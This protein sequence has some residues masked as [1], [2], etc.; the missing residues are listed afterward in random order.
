MRKGN[1]LIDD[2]KWQDRDS[3]CRHMNALA[4]VNYSVY[5][6]H[7]RGL[8]PHL[9][10]RD[11]YIYADP[12]T[13]VLVCLDCCGCGP[14]QTYEES[15]VTGPFIYD[16]NKEPRISMVWKLLQAV[17]QIKECLKPKNKEIKVL[18]ILLT[19]AT[20]MNDIDLEEYWESRDIMVL[21]GFKR[22]KFRN[23][24]VNDDTDLPG[25]AY[26]NA[27]LDDAVDEFSDKHAE[28][29]PSLCD[30][31]FDKMLTEFLFSEYENGSVDGDSDDES[32]ADEEDA[33][34]DETDESETADEEDTDDEEDFDDDD[35]D[36]DLLTDDDDDDDD[37]D[38]LGGLYIPDG[39]ITLTNNVQTSVEILRPIAN[40]REELDKLVGC[41]NIK[42]R[43]DELVALT[44]YNKRMLELFP[45]SKQ[46]SVSLHSIFLGR[47]GTGKTTV[48]K[49]FGS[50]MRQ[51]GALSK[52]HVVVCDRGT[53]IGGHWGDEECSLRQVLEKA[54]G[55]VLMIDEAY[56]L[57][58]PHPNDPGKIVIQLLMNIL[59][60]ESRRDIAVVLCGYKEPMMK[61]LD[62]NQGLAS[63]FPNRFEFKDF[64]VDEL[65]EITRRRLKDYEFI[66]TDQAWQKYRSVISQAYQARNSETWGNARFV[67]NQLE[68]I[69]IQH[70]SRCV[71][72]QPADKLS[73]RTITPDDIVPIE[74]PKPRARIGF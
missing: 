57:N 43:M 12:A 50:L 27:I 54:R 46:H 5:S 28:L 41:D 30:T 62:L 45:D 35:F 32:E 69:Y 20:I 71:S 40:P 15:K 1:R 23:I 22:L 3:I 67:A 55:G 51:A 37:D 53:F 60:D 47:P 72:Q 58:T 9:T 2:F 52:G 6:T 70:A 8:R 61:M 65:M 19:E 21:D 4:A 7:L 34:D 33:D 64:T 31:E 29:P 11:I 49:I 26:V 25:R 16:G 38:D 59:A 74:V 44:S 18:G 24:R 36:A 56:L 10:D 17:K 48:C 13:V 42:H 63:R 39:T 68:R 73:W 14:E 66:L